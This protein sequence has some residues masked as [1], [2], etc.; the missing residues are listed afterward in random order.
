[1]L[2]LS[3]FLAFLTVFIL[4]LSLF[5]YLDQRRPISRLDRYFNESNY[6][7]DDGFELAKKKRQKVDLKKTYREKVEKSEKE[8]GNLS[9]YRD[10]IDTRLDQAEI[11]LTVEEFFMAGLITT[12]ISGILIMIL[13]GSFLGTIIVVS[14]VPFLF[15]LYVRYKE[16]K[17][18]EMFNSQISDTMDMMAGTL[19][20][21]Y[22]FMQAMETISREM[23][24]PISKEFGKTIKEMRLG[25]KQEDALK[26]MVKR[27][28]SEDLDLLVTAII[29]NRQVGGNLAEIMDNISS[30]IRERYRIKGEVRVLTSQARLSGY[31]VMFLPFALVVFLFL[32]SPDHILS[33]F[34]DP[35][36]IIMIILAIAGQIIGY[37]FIRKFMDIRY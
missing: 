13:T 4:T 5:L 20:A 7:Y 8:K 25:I 37:M 26:D 32:F 10:L 23:P 14:V 21:G 24:K 29:I 9:Y 27:V 36:G 1:M 15:V 22:S 11:L 34:S 17:T 30:T 33:L 3:L 35:L 6:R 19:R 12:L 2:V 18:L 28:K 31:V 16:N